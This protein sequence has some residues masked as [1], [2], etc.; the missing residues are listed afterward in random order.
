MV[1]VVVY[2]SPSKATSFGIRIPGL[3]HERDQL[4]HLAVNVLEC[5]SLNCHHT[6]INNC[7]KVSWRIA[8]HSGSRTAQQAR[9]QLLAETDHARGLGRQREVRV[10]QQSSQN[11]Q[12]PR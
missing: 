3:S 9:L 10:E 12:R 5:Q 11:S 8:A 4:D 6:V 1:L 2:A 7:E